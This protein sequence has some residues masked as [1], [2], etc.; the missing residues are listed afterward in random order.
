MRSNYGKLE[1]PGM[2]RR[3]DIIILAVPL[4]SPIKEETTTAFLV[5]DESISCAVYIDPAVLVARV[6]DLVF[7]YGNS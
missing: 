1:L 4:S 3:I 7:H 2:N 5:Y 6:N